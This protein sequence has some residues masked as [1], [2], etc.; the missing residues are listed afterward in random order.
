MARRHQT[1][2]PLS[3]EHHDGLLLAWRLRTGDLATREPALKARHAAAFFES[4]LRA[5]FAAEE[6]VLF[7]AVR[8]ALGAHARLLDELVAQH[9]AMEAHAAKL[10]AGAFGEVIPFCDLLERHIR[11]EERELF[12]LIEQ[13]VAPAT[14]AAVETALAEAL[15]PP[16]LPSTAEVRVAGDGEE[17]A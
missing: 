14:L 4:R 6:E 1:L 2:I 10:R 11:T 8:A 12:P 7:P 13:H 3:R 15:A 17:K 16:A 5:H 9:G